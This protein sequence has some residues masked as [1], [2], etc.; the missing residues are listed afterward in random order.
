MADSLK[1]LGASFTIKRDPKSWGEIG[2][3]QARE[4][5][6]KS[7]RRGFLAAIGAGINEA[8]DAIA[9]VDTGMSKGGLIPAAKG[10]VDAGA[11]IAGL[12]NII[13]F[14]HVPDPKSRVAR[15]GWTDIQGEYHPGE[16]RGVHRG[17]SETSH[18]VTLNLGGVHRLLMTFNYALMVYQ[19]AKYED[20]YHALRQMRDTVDAHVFKGVE[21]A[22]LNMGRRLRNATQGRA[23]L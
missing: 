12:S 9:R 14:T 23:S 15:P 10:V 11:R 5:F 16:Y 22:W 17:A 7:V 13:T 8:F 21:E 3:K 18:S 19:W 20:E 2:G 1:G 6:Y 4:R